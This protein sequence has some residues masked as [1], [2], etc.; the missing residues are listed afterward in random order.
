[1]EEDISWDVILG[2]YWTV[3]A[4]RTRGAMSR[5]LKIILIAKILLEVQFER[6]I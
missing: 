1:M 2:W 6:Q 5:L 3:H 4:D